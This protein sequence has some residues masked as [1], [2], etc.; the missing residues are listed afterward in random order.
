MNRLWELFFIWFVAP[1]VGSFYGTLVG[2]QVFSSVDPQ[3][4]TAGVF[5]V[6]AII[7]IA[8]LVFLVGVL[9]FD[10]Y[11]YE[12]LYDAVVLVGQAMSFLIG[13]FMRHVHSDEDQ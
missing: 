11:Q 12:V 6:M 4:I 3:S 1:G 2:R 8:M 13:L 9:V 10:K 7:F 5:Y